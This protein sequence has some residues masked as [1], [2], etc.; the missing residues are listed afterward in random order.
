MVFSGGKPIDMLVGAVGEDG[1]RHFI[2][3]HI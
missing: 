3:K 2:Q 1:L